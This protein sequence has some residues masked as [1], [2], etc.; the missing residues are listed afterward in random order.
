MGCTRCFTGLLLH[1]LN[2]VGPAASPRRPQNFCS[3]LESAYHKLLSYVAN[4]D[5]AVAA[6][7]LGSTINDVH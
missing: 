6:A 2:S 7:L 4:P 1:I 3:G 5:A